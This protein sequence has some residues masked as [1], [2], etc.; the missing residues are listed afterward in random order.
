[1]SYKEKRET[2]LALRTER[3]ESI[4]TYAAMYGIAF[5]FLIPLYEMFKLSI[6]PAGYLGQFYWVPPEITLSI[7]ESVLLEEPILYRWM[8]NTF[9]IASVTTLL[10][11]VFD[12]LIA[13]SLTRLEWP[14]RKV[15]LG[16]IVASFM[17][18][19]YVNIIPLFQVV[20]EL[21][22][23]NSY[24]AVILPFTAGPLGVFLLYQF[25]KDI[26]E[27]LEEAAR[28]DG[29]STPRI[30]AQ[31]I[32]PLS[33]PIL[34]ALGLFTFV[35]SWNQFLWPLIVLGN[36]TMYT[37]P[38]GAVTLQAVYGE[39]SNQLMAMLAVVSLPLFIVFLVFQDKLISS[40]QLQASTG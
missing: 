19:A 20:N 17:V 3:V 10:V 27:E 26:P 8:L 39:F 31:I 33:R 34:S 11:L 40:V 15:V 24:W 37:I 4:V 30:Y 29:F 13:F 38:V 1:M 25:F 12:S 6:T 14:G 21:G 36:D 18:P 16:I 9:I 2:L 7:W 28:L 5:L 23:I 35:W 22:M 32:I